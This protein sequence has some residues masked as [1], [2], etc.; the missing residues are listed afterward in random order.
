MTD[1]ERAT[2]K[3]VLE[4]GLAW[5]KENPSASREMCWAQWATYNRKYE[6][7]R[8]KIKK[9]KELRKKK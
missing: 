1:E 5:L 2:L 6:P 4:Q 9:E 8:L 7:I 3:E